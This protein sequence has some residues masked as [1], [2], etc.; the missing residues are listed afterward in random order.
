MKSDYDK[1]LGAMDDMAHHH[2]NQPEPKG[3]AFAH[4]NPNQFAHEDYDTHWQAI[5]SC[6]VIQQYMDAK[7]TAKTLADTMGTPVKLTVWDGEPFRM[8]TN[9]LDE[10]TILP[11]RKNPA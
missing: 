4:I 8:G 2:N 1:A 10:E 7:A 3:G 5:K 6:E 9:E 11:T